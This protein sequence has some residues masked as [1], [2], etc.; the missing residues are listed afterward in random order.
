MLVPRDLD[1]RTLRLVLD[2][3]RQRSFT[4][5]A[6]RAH[7]SQSALSR[8]V[9][10]AERRLGIRLFDRTTRSVEPTPAGREFVRI[11]TRLVADHERGMRE[12]ALFRDGAGGLVRISALPSVA[13]TLLPSLVARLRVDAP[14]VTIDIHD[15]L[16]HDAIEDLVA[17]R[18]DLAIAGDAGLPAGTAFAPLLSD[19]FH[20]VHPH[21]HRFADGDTVTWRELAEETLVM[22]G[23]SS[24]L[25]ILTDATLGALDAR[26]A[27]TIEAQ[28]I[29][30]IAG[31]VAAGLGVAAAPATVLP[32]MAF[33][34]LAAT[35]LASPEVD[36]TL[37]IVTVPDRST[38]PAAGRVIATLGTMFADGASRA[39]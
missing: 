19:R 12:F 31:L 30:V 16:A 27:D 25:R 14:D 11:A 26:P 36:R 2:V 23:P 4:M 17:G 24:S 38:S 28:N 6:E 5:A 29:A 9:N 18:A 7:L 22:F 37:G 34:D 3:A 10:D 15:V 39:G 21:D 20:A 32:L 8:A 35:P 33:A 13:A 1:L